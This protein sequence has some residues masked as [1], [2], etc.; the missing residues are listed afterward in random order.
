MPPSPR[1]TLLCVLLLAATA[2]Q[3]RC[4]QDAAVSSDGQARHYFWNEVTGQVQWEDP[5]NTAFEDERGYRCAPR[6]GVQGMGWGARAAAGA[7][8]AQLLLHRYWNTAQ[9]QKVHEDPD[10]YKFV[11]V[12]ALRC[13]LQ[14]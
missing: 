11:W 10:A 6:A 14:P 2:A 1:S 12:S 3:H 13:T 8:R 4:S 9:G 7:Q 5:G